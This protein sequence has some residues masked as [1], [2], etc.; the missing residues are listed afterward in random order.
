MFPLGDASYALAVAVQRLVD[1]QIVPA[2]YKLIL[3]TLPSILDPRGATFFRRDRAEDEDGVAP[4][5]LCGPD[6]EV[7][8][9]KTKRALFP[10]VTMLK[11]RAGVKK[12][13][14]LEGGD[15]PSYA[16]FIL[17]AF[18][19]WVERSNVEDW[20]TLMN[21]GEGE[22]RELWEACEWCFEGMGE[23]ER[24]WEWKGKGGEPEHPG[25]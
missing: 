4:E 6:S 19:G 10:L 12:G 20:E 16:D 18:F 9:T 24:A 11:G 14:F 8:W 3:R 17:V 1:V 2:S 23:G 5:D 7:H 13:P 15:T 22:F 25:E 21:M